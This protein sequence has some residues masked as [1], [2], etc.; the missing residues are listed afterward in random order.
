MKKYRKCDHGTYGTYHGS[1]LSISSALRLCSW[2]VSEFAAA[3]NSV[4]L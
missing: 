2:V 4:H 3:N 1:F